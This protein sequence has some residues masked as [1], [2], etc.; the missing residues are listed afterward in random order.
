MPPN[1]LCQSLPPQQNKS[2]SFKAWQSVLACNWV[3]DDSSVI[4]LPSPLDCW[5]RRADAFCRSDVSMSSRLSE[6]VRLSILR[7]RR[8]SVIGR[9]TRCL[10]RWSYRRRMSSNSWFSSLSTTVTL[11]KTIRQSTTLRCAKT[12]SFNL[13]SWRY[14]LDWSK[15]TLSYCKDSVRLR[16]VQDHS[17]SLILVPTESQY[18]TSY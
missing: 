3:T 5:R 4:N 6:R 15:T 2:T 17:K 1:Q 18:A 14:L 16:S 9:N 8:P 11:H 12:T 7:A 10:G 13:H